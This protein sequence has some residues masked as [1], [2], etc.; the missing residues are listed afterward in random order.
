MQVEDLGKKWAML[1]VRAQN[2]GRIP[3]IQHLDVIC[4]CAVSCFAAALI[5]WVRHVS[6]SPQQEVCYAKGVCI[7]ITC[8]FKIFVDSKREK[9]C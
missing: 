4:C 8:E 2:T 9:P 7:D 5:R 1:Q 6:R 3:K